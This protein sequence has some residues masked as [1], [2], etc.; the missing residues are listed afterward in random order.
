MAPAHGKDVLELEALATAQAYRASRRERGGGG[1]DRP[2][3]NGPQH[4][5]AQKTRKKTQKTRFAGRKK[6]HH[7]RWGG[8]CVAQKEIFP[9]SRLESPRNLPALSPICNYGH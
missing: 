7:H 6:T 5:G 2:S 8:P 4:V 3:E 1:D 9:I